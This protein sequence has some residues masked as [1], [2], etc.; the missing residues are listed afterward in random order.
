MHQLALKLEL[1]SC[2]PLLE[3]FEHPLLVGIALAPECGED[4]EKGPGI[5]QGHGANEF[6][7]DEE[8]EKLLGG[9]DPPPVLTPFRHLYI[10]EER[11]RRHLCIEPHAGKNSGHG[12]EPALVLSRDLGGNLWMFEG[13]NARLL[14]GLK[15]A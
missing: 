12:P 5:V 2:H 3:L 13:V 7:G 1:Q 11:P 6:V 14:D 10:E 9:R 8:L 15:L 4:A